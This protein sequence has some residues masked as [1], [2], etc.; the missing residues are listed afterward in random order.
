LDKRYN[1][2]TLYR[3]RADEVFIDCGAY[4]GDTLELFLNQRGSTFTRFIA[5]EPDPKNF[6]TLQSFFATLPESTQ[7]RISCLPYASTDRRTSIRFNSGLEF[8][9]RIDANAGNIEVAGVPL[10]EICAGL[11]VSYIKMDIEGAEPAAIEGA[12][13]ILVRCAPIVAACVYH[14]QDHLWCLILQHHLINPDY[15]FFLRRYEDEYGDVVLYAVP[16]SR[17]HS[18]EAT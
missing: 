5:L 17:L 4:T 11:D 6:A 16:P 2:H 7:A 1:E 13:Q 3:P 9:S 18:M 15:R 12:R 10:D 14:Q 8:S